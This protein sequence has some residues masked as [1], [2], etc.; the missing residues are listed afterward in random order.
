MR[1]I[2]DHLG[3]E[4]KLQG[5]KQTGGGFFNEGPGGQR[6]DPGKIRART[7]E[8][9]FDD[10]PFDAVAKTDERALV[11]YRDRGGVGD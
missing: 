1:H 4:N 5:W 9:G 8:P 6:D 3:P 7:R 2:R 11:R 10:Q